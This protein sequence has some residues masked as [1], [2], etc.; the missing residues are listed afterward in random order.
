[1]GEGGPVGEGRTHLPRVHGQLVIEGVQP[2]HRRD[3][4]RGNPRK[5]TG[6]GRSG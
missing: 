3:S 5:Q 4:R 2:G 6:S 1:M